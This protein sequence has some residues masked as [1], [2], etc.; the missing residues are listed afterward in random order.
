MEEAPLEEPKND[1]TENPKSREARQS[2]ATIIRIEDATR[3]IKIGAWTIQEA[4]KLR[5]EDQKAS[6]IIEREYAVW[7][8]ERRKEDAKKAAK[9]ERRIRTIKL[10]EHRIASGLCTSCGKQSEKYRCDACNEY[11]RNRKREKN[12]ARIT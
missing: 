7:L 12:R 10:R 8:S 9:E 6:R 4:R 1:K 2:K 11:E 5:L 3:R